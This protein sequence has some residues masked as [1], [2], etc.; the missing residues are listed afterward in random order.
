MEPTCS[1]CGSLLKA[2]VKSTGNVK[3]CLLALILLFTGL[4]ICCIPIFGWIIGPLICIYA[5][6][7]GGKRRK[8]WVCTNCHSVF[9]RG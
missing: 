6:F 1:F 4:M 7:T 5:L 2:K 9:D 8:V 3:G